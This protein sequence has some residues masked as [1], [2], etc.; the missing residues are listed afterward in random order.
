L[1]IWKDNTNTKNLELYSCMGVHDGAGYPIAYCLLST[2]N[3]LEIGKHTKALTAWAKHLRDEY[4]IYPDFANVDNDMALIGM[5]QAV[6]LI[7]KVA[8]CYW[9]NRKAVGERLAKTKLSTSPYSSKRVHA[10]FNF[11]D[12]NW[13]PPGRPDKNEHEGGI[14]DD[15]MNKNAPVQD[16]PNAV[17]I[18]IR[19]PTS[20]PSQP[21][22]PPQDSSSKLPVRPVLG[23]IVNLPTDAAAAPVPG[24]PMIRLLPPRLPNTQSEPPSPEPEEVDARRTFCPL[25]NRQPIID[26]MENHYCAHPLIPGYSHPSAAGIRYWAVKQMYEY[27]VDHDLREAWAYLWENWYR[28][29]RWEIWARS[30]HD[31]IPTLKTTMVMESQ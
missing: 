31:M 15:V 26:M 6:W 4:G 10:E 18:R 8:L 14:H 13:R 28:S 22:P 17:H 29:G 7:I 20:T 21:V 12:V 2:A 1:G 5:S 27:C 24:K 16:N 19:L 23:D 30:A 25:E 11:I 9:H 3:S